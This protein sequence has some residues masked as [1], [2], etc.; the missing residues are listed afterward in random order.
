MHRDQERGLHSRCYSHRHWLDRHHY[1][2]VHLYHCLPKLHY[3]DRNRTKHLRHC[4]PKPNHLH[5]CCRLLKHS[6][7]HRDRVQPDHH[8]HPV[9]LGRYLHC[10][11]QPDRHCVRGSLLL[12]HCRA[13]HDHH[14]PH[15][16]TNRGR[17][18]SYPSFSWY[19]RWL[20]RRA[21]SNH[22]RRYLPWCRQQVVRCRCCRFPRS[23]CLPVVNGRRLI[24]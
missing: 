6:H 13:I 11:P 17:C 21:Q 15:T 14:R 3:V 8:R 24:S 18:F 1:P 2:R 23:R 22:H 9:T 7:P 10:H 16:P 19:H 20:G 4:L 12:P 5:R